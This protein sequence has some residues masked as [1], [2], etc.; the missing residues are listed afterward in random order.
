MYIYFRIPRPYGFMFLRRHDC[1]TC[2]RS[3]HN[4]YSSTNPYARDD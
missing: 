2:G 1:H 4:A 3:H